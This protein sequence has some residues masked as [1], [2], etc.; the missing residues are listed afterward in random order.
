MSKIK[1][2]S[3]AN[4]IL[5]ILA[6]VLVIVAMVMAAGAAGAA[7]ST[8][9]LSYEAKTATVVGA[10]SGLIA[11]L[12]IA[13]FSGL[14]QFIIQIIMTILA[15]KHEKKTIMILLIIGFFV[16]ILTLVASIMIL[17]NKEM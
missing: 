14:A 7:A 8:T 4:I 13:S 3:I 17:A 6:I 5:P 10:S 1:K 2:L 9:D 15:S 12:F 11:V 16:P